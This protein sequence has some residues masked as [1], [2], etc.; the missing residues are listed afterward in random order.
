MAAMC[1]LRSLNLIRS[2]IQMFPTDSSSDSLRHH[3][4]HQH[5]KFPHSNS[6]PTESLLSLYESVMIFI[7]TYSKLL[8][9]PLRQSSSV[10]HRYSLQQLVL[11]QAS[12]GFTTTLN[13]HL[14]IW[15]L[16]IP[17]LFKDVSNQTMLLMRTLRCVLSSTYSTVY[18]PSS[19]EVTVCILHSTLHYSSCSYDCIQLSQRV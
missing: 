9:L 4:H 17:D 19:V 3:H 8:I 15:R 10:Q 7:K 5:G 12:L 2:I 16:K 14:P 6:I 13:T 18:P 11:I 1:W